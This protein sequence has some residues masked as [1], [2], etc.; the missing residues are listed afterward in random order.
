MVL[1]SDGL[2]LE[3]FVDAIEDQ[4]KEWMEAMQEEMDSLHKNHTYEL[5]KLPKGKKA[6]KNKWVYRTKQEE[7]MPHPRFKARLVM[8]GFGQRK[9][10]DFD[11]IFSSFV[12]MTSIRVI[13]GLAASLNLEVEQM[14]VKTTF[15]HGDLEEEI[16]ME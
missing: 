12:K 15:L 7:H 11:E 3:C 1:L 9:G 4:Y 16:Y 10:V 8:K 13:I 6:L 2:E 5:V 14:D